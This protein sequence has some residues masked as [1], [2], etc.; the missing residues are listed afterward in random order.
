MKNQW[1]DKKWILAVSGGPD[2]MALFKLCLN[3]GVEVV[4]AHVN[5]KK[6]ETADRDEQG[7]IEFCRENNIRLETCYPKQME[8]GN[9]QGW[10][11]KARY[12]FFKECA[13]KHKAYGVLV[14]HH[15]DDVIETYLL[16]RK[17]RAIPRYYGIHP[18][19]EVEKVVVYRPIL[20]WTKND[21]V[22][23]CKENDVPYFIDESN[24]KDEYQ[25]NKFRHE[26]IEKL[27]AQQRLEFLNEIDLK[28]QEL[29]KKRRG[30]EKY[31]T[32]TLDVSEFKSKS[33]DQR[34]EIVRA[35]MIHHDVE[36]ASFSDRHMRALANMLM[37]SKNLKIPLKSKRLVKQGTICEIV[38]NEDKS[39]TIVL[40]SYQS[41]KNDYFEVSPIGDSKCGVTVTE[42]DY[43]LTIRNV[44]HGDVIQLQSG[45]KK[46]HRWFIDQ[47]IP[48][49]EREIWP[50]VENSQKEIILVPEMGC[51]VKHYTVKPNLFVVK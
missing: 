17:R 12:Q 19:S 32:H 21:C 14:G 45:R 33:D 28:N 44:R 23:Y 25:R 24:L 34:A 4:A 22:H 46:V 20:S 3:L 9:F 11:R 42:E 29:M 6:R 50:V 35:W 2:S 38:G 51:D 8:K 31:C 26:V 16:Q 47:K 43:P 7:I 30:L 13:E 36:E 37:S 15:Q 5:Y 39:Y 18:E 10:A 41:I 27:T 49:L 48:L 1:T 40:Q